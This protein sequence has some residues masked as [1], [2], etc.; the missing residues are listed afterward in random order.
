MKIVMGLTSHDR[1]GD[2][3]CR[4]G[5]GLEESAAPHFVLRDAGV[6]LA[7]ASPKGT[8]P[9]VAPRSDL[10]KHQAPATAR[11]T[12]DEEAQRSLAHS[13][14]HAD[15]NSSDFD[16]VFYVAGHGRVRGLAESLA[17]TGLLEPSYNS[18]KPIA[19]MYQ[20]P[21]VLRHVAYEGAPLVRG[22]RVKDFTSEKEAAV[23]LTKVV[24]FLVEDELKWLGAK[25]AKV[26]SWQ[27]F[28]TGDGNLVTGQNPASSPSAAQA[29][30][31]SLTIQ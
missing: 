24:P 7:L 11:F 26:S 23:Q 28:S 8:Q 3:G 2:T 20:S 16:A 10:P 21:G 17:S 22:K 13:A 14:R 18:G 6:E 1:L 5:F 4:T 19:L 27:P 12:R 9:P 31:K 29:L 30:L 15:V 25:F